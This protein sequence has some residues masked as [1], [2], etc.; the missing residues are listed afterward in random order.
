M[1]YSGLLPFN[2]EN[3]KHVEILKQYI[4]V[5]KK[6]FPNELYP[7]AEKMHIVVE[8]MFVQIFFSTLQSKSFKSESSILL[9]LLGN[10]F[11]AMYLSGPNRLM[12]NE[13]EMKSKTLEY[14]VDLFYTIDNII[15]L[16]EVK[17]TPNL[18]LDLGK[19]SPQS[20]SA[21]KALKQI[22]KLVTL[23]QYFNMP[24]EL[25]FINFEGCK[26]DPII[27]SKLKEKGVNLVT[28][29]LNINYILKVSNDILKELYVTA[30][31][32][33]AQNNLSPVGV[34]YSTRRFGKK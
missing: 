27:E 29:P 4:S 10:Y 8:K 28:I 7:L 22:D 6:I 2:M 23:K 17:A 34:D 20:D 32:I 30:R 18:L 3:P 11:A 13:A 5:A 15:H 25:D 26:L 16:G 21:S 1:N 12:V 33:A 31:D 14:D 19:G 9:G 24:M